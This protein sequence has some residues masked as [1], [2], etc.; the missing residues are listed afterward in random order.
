[1]VLFVVLAGLLA[2]SPKAA[3]NEAVVSFSGVVP[4]LAVTA[5]TAP[6]VPDGLPKRSE[7]GV[8]ALFP[9]ADRLYMVSY[10]SVPN[11]GAGT[12]LYEIDEDLNMLKIANHSS[13]YANR[14][15]H[16]WT[17]S[18]IIG[19]YVIDAQRH[20]RTITDLLGVR[21]GAC[22]EH[23]FKPATHIY[24][25]SMDGPFYEVELST[26]K[27]TQL[28]DLVQELEIPV[29][30]DPHTTGTTIRMPGYKIVSI[31]LERM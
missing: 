20:V 4:S 9:W 10:L 11:Y 21:I 16:H 22:A 6:V 12:G 30:K 14:M 24:M 23:L 27:A 25:V 26:L 2:Y 17:D 18:L 13:V 19:P 28:F 29:S 7:S 31:R 1:M 5:E 15:L 8:G 3:R